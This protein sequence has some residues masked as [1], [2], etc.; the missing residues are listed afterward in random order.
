MSKF[1]MKKFTRS[2]C[3]ILNIQVDNLSMDE[4]LNQIEYGFIVTPNID[5]LVRLQKDKDFF[6]AYESAD[7][8]LCDSQLLMRSAHFLGINFKEKLSGSDFLPAFFKFHA[9]HSDIRVFLLGG[10]T[11]SPETVAHKINQKVGRMM[12]VGGYSPPFGFEYDLQECLSIIRQIQQSKATVLVV[13][14]G[15]PK[16]EKWIATYRNQLP[17]VKIFMA[18]GATIDFE[19]GNLSRAPKW[20]QDTGLEWL[21]RLLSEPKR[22]WR[23]YLIEDPPFFWFLLKQRLGLY[24]SP[25]Q[26]TS[27]KFLIESSSE[28]DSTTKSLS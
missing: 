12:V 10:E 18:L 20:T 14:V 21:Y 11:N 13:G 28:L 8:R 27:Q 7:Y 16:Q 5:H 1:N 25:F 24:R 26:S 23:R 2:T 3:E 6:R 22:L 15:A 19:A 4:A 17:S 9:D